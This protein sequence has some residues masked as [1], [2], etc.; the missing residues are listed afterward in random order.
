MVESAA[1]PHN[2]KVTGNG[3]RNLDY[4]CFVAAGAFKAGCVRH[5][6]IIENKEWLNL[7]AFYKSKNLCH[8]CHST[9]DTFLAVPNNLASA[10]RRNYDDFVIHAC[11]NGEKSAHLRKFVGDVGSKAGEKCLPSVDTCS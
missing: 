8:L 6:H 7:S 11:K 2:S 1:T 10:S 4:V 9:D 3:T 5:S